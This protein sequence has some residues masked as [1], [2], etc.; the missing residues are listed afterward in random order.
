MNNCLIA[1]L[2]SASVLAW[3]APSGL[4]PGEF[5]SGL[6]PG[7]KGWGLVGRDGRDGRVHMPCSRGGTCI[8]VGTLGNG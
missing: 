6:G 5:E 1:S 8:P 4:G 3:A 7:W 2:V